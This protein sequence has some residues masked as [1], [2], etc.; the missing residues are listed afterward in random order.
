MI[1]NKLKK[2]KSTTLTWFMSL[3]IDIVYRLG[4][5]D[6]GFLANTV[7]S[8]AVKEDWLK[9]AL[10]LAARERREVRVGEAEW[11]YRM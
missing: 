5:N 7:V 4:W 9:C 1:K 10:T 2:G 8:S 6:K 3:D 11:G